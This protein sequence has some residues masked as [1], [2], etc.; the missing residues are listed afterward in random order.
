[1]MSQCLMVS[2]TKFRHFVTTPYGIGGS[3]MDEITFLVLWHDRKTK[4][5]FVHAFYQSSGVDRMTKNRV[6]K[7]KVM[8]CG[9]TLAS[10]KISKIFQ[11]GFHH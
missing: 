6:S 3:Y 1:M 10:A 9:C 7:K 11:K 5:R 8:R 4:A 2:K